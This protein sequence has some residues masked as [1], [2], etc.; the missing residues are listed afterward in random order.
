[1]N[2]RRG[3]L[4]LW[5]LAS[6]LWIALVGWL[7]VSEITI[8][9]QSSPVV[10]EAKPPGAAS[11]MTKE[12]NPF[13]SMKR[14]RYDKKPESMLPGIARAAF[15]PPLLLLALGVMFGWALRGFKPTP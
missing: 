7:Y 11:S 15:L 8:A 4:R 10:A 3:L 14:S 1:M 6:V 13:L 5:L 9:L 12:D 2:Y